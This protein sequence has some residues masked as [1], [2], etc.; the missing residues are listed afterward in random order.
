MN[1]VQ[2]RILVHLKPFGILLKPNPNK[3]SPN[4]S[5][6][7]RFEST[8]KTPKKRNRKAMC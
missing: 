5:D 2:I 7:L 4:L 3:D 1:P 6:Q 8:P